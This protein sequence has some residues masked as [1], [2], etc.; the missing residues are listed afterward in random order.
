MSIADISLAI[1]TGIAASVVI[2]G[3]LIITW[4]LCVK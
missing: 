1:G 4:F 3:I 2:A